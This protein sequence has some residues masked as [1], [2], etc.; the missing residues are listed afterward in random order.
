MPRLTLMENLP[1]TPPAA[2]NVAYT[3]SNGNPPNNWVVNAVG[4][5]TNTN[6][7]VVNNP[8]GINLVT[9]PNVATRKL[10][11]HYPVPPLTRDIVISSVQP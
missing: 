8:P 6:V 10:I 4:V 1:A 2:L 11:A 9:Q 3:Y 5:D 7:I